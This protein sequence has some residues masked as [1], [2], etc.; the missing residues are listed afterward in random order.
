M[1]TIKAIVV[2]VCLAMMTSCGGS[3]SKQS[4][5][6]DGFGAIEDEIKSEF[7]DDAYYTDLTITYNK[8]IGNII[9]VTVTE[10]P[11]SLKMGQWNNTQ[12]TWTQSSEI[13]LEVPEGS[14]AKDFMFQLGETI[15]LTKLGGLVEKSIQQLKDEKNLKNPILSIAS[16][17]FPD[18]G[19][20]SEARFVI[21]LKP[22][23]GGTSFS[24]YYKLD[25]E[26]IKMDS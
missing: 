6:A 23:N 20:A 18:N 10:D 13:S 11:T 25:G 24:F 14:Q 3:A 12:G 16:I 5:D 21:N 4:A 17:D 15:N 1:K 8:S 9:G 22:E 19:N 26:L 2:L 7:S